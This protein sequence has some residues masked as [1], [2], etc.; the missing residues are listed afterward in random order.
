MLVFASCPNRGQVKVYYADGDRIA[1]MMRC[2]SAIVQNSSLFEWIP[3]TSSIRGVRQLRVEWEGKAYVGFSALNL[4]LLLNP[5][6][7]L[8]VALL[9]CWPGLP[10]SVHLV[11]LLMTLIGGALWFFPWVEVFDGLRR[12]LR[13]IR[14]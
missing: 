4:W 10:R 9:I 12:G 13:R 14:S 7:Y 5:L 2:I 3:F 8:A 6:T 1:R 11:L